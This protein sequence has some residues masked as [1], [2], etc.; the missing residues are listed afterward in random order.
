[1]RPRDDRNPGTDENR[2]EQHDDC[3]PS[4][5]GRSYTKACVGTN[6]GR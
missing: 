3:M 5:R 1:M 6:T 2:R 4:H